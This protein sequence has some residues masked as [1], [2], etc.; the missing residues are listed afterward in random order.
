MFVTLLQMDARQ[1]VRDRLSFIILVIGLVCAFAAAA[2]GA[3]WIDRLQ[4][5]RTAFLAADA[6]NAVKF[7]GSISKAAADPEAAAGLPSRVTRPVAFP[8]PRLADFS[9]GRSDIEPTTATLRMRARADTLFRNYQID[10]PER[11][12]RGRLDLS[13]V[14][15]VLSP[16][17]LIAL[18]YGVFASDRE[19]GTARLILAQA[20]SPAALLAARSVN[21]LALVLA[22]LLL[23][24][25]WLL[26]AGPAI[27]GRPAA[28]GL[29]LTVA[30]LGLLF[31][32]A[33]VLLVNSLRVTAESAALALIATWALLVF[34][35]PAAIN[36]G[37]QAVYPPPSRLTQIVEGRAA[38][39][40]ANTAY[41]NDHPTLAVTGP[42]RVRESIARNYQIGLDVER[43]V[44]P[45]VLA[46]ETHLA[47]QQALVARAQLTSP[48]MTVAGVLASI[49]GTDAAAYNGLRAGARESL[50]A[51]KRTL[52]EPVEKGRP[53]DATMD[54]EFK[55]YLPDHPS[56]R[57]PADAW[58]VAAL[59]ALAG[60]LA[61]ARLRRASPILGA[62]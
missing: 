14:A 17:L 18:G 38:E 60:G 52:A 8:T 1:L 58:W 37:A 28:A 33:L 53:F 46:F 29:W 62:A 12:A 42:A 19:R 39:I 6:E 15:V 11:L 44:A 41:E 24:A 21:R 50:T 36:A 13:F 25:G 54:A 9:I 5:E 55:A 48:S 7:L 31:W 3:A 16:L 45:G 34:V 20:G 32:W 30:A 57:L 22:P 49:A 10:N 51:F 23:G 27:E 61:A 40:G 2:T 56:V 43:Q 26:L 4:A 47:R 35:A 59:T